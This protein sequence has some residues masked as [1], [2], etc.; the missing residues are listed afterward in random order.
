MVAR[1]TTVLHADLTREIPAIGWIE[2]QGIG[3]RSVLDSLAALSCRVPVASAD[4]AEWDD[5]A[6]KAMQ[7]IRAL[8]L[9]QGGVLVVA[10]HRPEL[11]TRVRS[12]KGF[13][14]QLGISGGVDVEYPVE[15]AYTLFVSYSEAL[16]VERG[17]LR[18]C[19]FSMLQGFVALRSS[20]ADLARE[21]PEPSKWC[22]VSSS[23]ARLDT[24]RLIPLL[25]GRA[26]G[27]CSMWVPAH[28]ESLTVR[29]FDDHER[30]VALKQVLDGLL[31]S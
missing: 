4:D 23:S 16:G 12:H 7:V 30:C 27:V 26:R 11:R 1:F 17:V 20:A 8:L 6:A 13:S 3:L 29:V 14:A 25:A 22:D 31:P 28:G 18:R 15:Q 5:A 21:M 24:R 9:D 19:M 10:E 2:P